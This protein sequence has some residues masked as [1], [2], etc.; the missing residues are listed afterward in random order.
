MYLDMN[1][2]LAEPTPGKL[3]V[4]AEQEAQKLV[5]RAING[6]LYKIEISAFECRIVSLRNKYSDTQKYTEDVVLDAVSLDYQ[7]E[8]HLERIRKAKKRRLNWLKDIDI[9]LSHN[10]IVLRET[11]QQTIKYI[12]LGYGVIFVTLIGTL[13]SQ[14][15]DNEFFP[16]IFYS[17][18]VFALGFTLVIFGLAIIHIMT[19]QLLSNLRTLKD[20]QDIEKDKKTWIYKV[21][22]V[23]EFLI[24]LSAIFII[25]GI[26]V[27]VYQSSSIY[28]L[29]LLKSH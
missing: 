11:G 16:A 19:R 20:S 14:K 10:L 23:G 17:L 8:G 3:C 28:S 29:N 25:L 15:F 7:L 2:E 13:F 27:F 5:S 12:L 6:I 9:L 26:V 18:N 22:L 24:I 1:E 21:N 4:W